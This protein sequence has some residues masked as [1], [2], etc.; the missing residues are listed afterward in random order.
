MSKELLEV[1]NGRLR[2]NLHYGQ[3]RAWQSMKRFIAVL[4]GTQGG[5][6]SFGPLWL[7]REIALCGP[8]DYMVVTPTFPLLELKALPEFRNYF[9]DLLMLGRYVGSPTRRFIFSKAGQK[10]LFGDYGRSYR[11]RVLFGYAADPDSLESA[12][13]KALWGD[14]A[15][16]KKFKQSSWEALLRRLSLDSGRALLTTTIYNLKWLKKLLYDPWLKSGRNH[17]DIDIINFPS[18]ANPKFPHAEMARAKAEMPEWKY[19]MFYLGLFTRPAGQIYSN[20]DSEQDT[21]SRFEIPSGWK[22]YI[23]LDFGGVNTAATLYARHPETSTLYLHRT[24]HQGGLTSAQHAK[25]ILRLIPDVQRPYVVG[26]SKSEGQWRIEFRAGGLPV[27]A[28]KFSDVEVGIDRVFAAHSRREVVVFEDQLEYLAEKE[29]YARVLDEDGEPTDEIENKT[30]FHL[31]DSERYL[32]T[33]IFKPPT[34][35][36]VIPTQQIKHH[37]KFGGRL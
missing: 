1:D 12:T 18:T 28:P 29:N 36:T 22:H 34:H 35:E 8:G 23:G 32:G 10:R 16:Q 6:T 4:A 24:Y 13:A 19:R 11:T 21:C 14:E 26:G 5:K 25:A 33:H 3:S 30:K 9:E 37:Q 15:G 7:Q 31:M 2:L 20:F 27:R 17:P